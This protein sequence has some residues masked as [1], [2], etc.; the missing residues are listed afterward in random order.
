MVISKKVVIVDDHATFNFA[1]LARNAVAKL[2][3]LYATFCDG[4]PDQRTVGADVRAGFTGGNYVFHHEP[5]RKRHL[6]IEETRSAKQ[7]LRI[8]SRFLFKHRLATQHAVTRNGLADRQQIVGDHTQPDE[9]Q[10]AATVFVNR[11]SEA[12]PLYQVRRDAA[13]AAAFV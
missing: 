3:V 1:F 6:C 8:H 4:Y 11:N 9:E 10:A 7:S 13:Q 2:Y 12:Q 5:F